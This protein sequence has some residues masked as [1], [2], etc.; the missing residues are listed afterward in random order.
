[1][2]GGGDGADFELLAQLPHGDGGDHGG[3]FDGLWSGDDGDGEQHRRARLWFMPIQP[4]D[5]DEGDLPHLPLR[6]GHCCGQR[7]LPGRDAADGKE[8]VMRGTDCTK[9]QIQ[10]A[11]L[12]IANAQAGNHKGRLF[13]P[14]ERII[15]IPFGKMARLVAWYGAVRYIAG[16]DHSG[17]TLESPGP[18]DGRKV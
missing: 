14:D 10:S 18:I 9:D 16:R 8:P 17:G 2:R 4:D 6:H 5:A 15:Q 13:P 1:M 7:E 12:F 11:R 3:E